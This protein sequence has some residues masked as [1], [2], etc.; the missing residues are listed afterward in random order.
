[1]SD[2]ESDE[3]STNSNSK[4]AEDVSKDSLRLDPPSF[5]LPASGDYQVWSVRMP[6]D[7]DIKALQGV[8]LDLSN[9]ILGQFKSKKEPYGLTLG[10]ATEHDSFRW[11]V[12]AEDKMLVPSQSGFDK[13]VN[14]VHMN[15]LRERKET[16]V[17][18]RAEMAPTPDCF[19]RHAY[20]SVPPKTN[21]K[22]RWRMPGSGAV[23][24]EETANGSDA[25][26][27]KRE[28]SVVSPPTPIKEETHSPVTPSSS[29]SKSGKKEKKSKSEKKS[30][31]KEKKEKKV[32]SSQ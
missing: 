32:K 27:V 3:E 13:H 9:T 28:N 5:S 29:K 12:A 18:P 25:K 31:K 7:M 26:R 11:L 1:M 15:A 16:D 4:E 19:V 21:L 2:S 22:R 14:I 6:L 10:N 20:S 17:A 8:E 24:M 30:A 23:V